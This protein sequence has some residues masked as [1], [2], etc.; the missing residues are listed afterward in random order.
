MQSH[1][2]SRS[3]PLSSNVLEQ[4]ARG[5]AL[6]GICNYPGTVRRHI[7]YDGHRNPE[8]GT[9]QRSHLFVIYQIG[10]NGPENGFPACLVVRGLS[11]RWR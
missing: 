8:G 2:H 10:R 6:H 5:G 3:V 7:F 1:L 11:L 4:V 9:L